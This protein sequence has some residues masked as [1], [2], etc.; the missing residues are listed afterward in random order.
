M[1]FID[2]VIK[3]GQVFDFTEWKVDQKRHSQSGD[4]ILLQMIPNDQKLNRV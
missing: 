3:G 1:D 4:G 2:D